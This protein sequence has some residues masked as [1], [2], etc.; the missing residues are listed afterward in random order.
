[1]DSK[2][3][4]NKVFSDAIVN[5]IFYGFGVAVIVFINNILKWH[6]LAIILAAVFAIIVLIS[7]VPFLISLIMGIIAIP[8]VIKEKSA[9]NIEVIRNQLWLWAGSIVQ[10]VEN[11]IFVYMVYYLYKILF[12]VY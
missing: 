12:I 8:I 2:E 9:G 4:F 10:L 3:V 5:F 7:L 1:M 11:T 6:T